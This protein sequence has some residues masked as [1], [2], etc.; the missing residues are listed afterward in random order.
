MKKNVLISIVFCLAGF[1]SFAQSGPVQ[2]APSVDLPSFLGS[3]YEIASMPQFFQRNCAKNTIANYS[4]DDAGGI[5]VVNTCVKKNGDLITA[6]G[7]AKVADEA[8]NSKLS[9]TFLKLGTWI[10][11]TSSNYWILDVPSDYRFAVVGT[12]NADYGW[13]LSRTP[14]I[15][16]EDLLAATEVLRRNGFDLCKFDITPQDGGSPQKLNLCD[17]VN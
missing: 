15:S 17:I 2:A 13:I 16:E 14:R 9:V 10:Y 6:S 1:Q 7:K 5:N 12:K 3:W 4:L 11:I 8:T